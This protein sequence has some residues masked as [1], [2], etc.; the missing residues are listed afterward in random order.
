[1]SEERYDLSPCIDE[2][3][4]NPLSF[5][6]EQRLFELCQSLLRIPKTVPC[7]CLQDEDF[8]DVASPS[9][10]TGAM[11]SFPGQPDGLA[12]MPPGYQ[13]MEAFD[14]EELVFFREDEAIDH[15]LPDECR[16]GGLQKRHCLLVIRSLDSHSRFQQ[17]GAERHALD[18]VLLRN[19][20]GLSQIGGGQIG[21]SQRQLG[22]G[23]LH[24]SHSEKTE[25]IA[26]FEECNRLRQLLERLSHPVFFLK[27]QRQPEPQERRPYTAQP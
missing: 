13:N 9:R 3:A 16:L 5:G 24:E 26:G 6:K 23:T 11:Q 22:A 17:V 25:C 2:G 4:N 21:P 18:V 8:D 15:I 14:Q 27:H 10:R 12:E 1:M 19:L 7:R 20:P